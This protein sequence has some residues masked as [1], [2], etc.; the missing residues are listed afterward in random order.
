MNSNSYLSFLFFLWFGLAMGSAQE[1]LTP[2]QLK[3]NVVAYKADIRG[4][5]KDIRWFCK[6]GSIRQPNSQ[7]Y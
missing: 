4:P 5:Y 2:I 3:S 7:W 6:D 1:A